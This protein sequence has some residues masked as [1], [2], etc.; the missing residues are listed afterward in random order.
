MIDL[1]IKDWLFHAPI[2]K[3]PIRRD[4]SL[5]VYSAIPSKSKS[6]AGEF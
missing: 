3:I 1:P 6:E 5:P 4:S 2:R